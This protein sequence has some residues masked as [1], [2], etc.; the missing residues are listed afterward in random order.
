MGAFCKR[1]S[2]SILEWLACFCE[3]P[4]E[5]TTVNGSTANAADLTANKAE[6]GPLFPPLP[7]TSADLTKRLCELKNKK[8]PNGKAN[9]R[10]R[11]TVRLSDMQST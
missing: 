11:W 3:R 6:P 1:V 8:I 7:Q 5:I 2:D 10:N 4:G 9:I